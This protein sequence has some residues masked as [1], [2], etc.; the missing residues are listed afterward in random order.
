MRKMMREGTKPSEHAQRLMQELEKILTWFYDQ[1]VFSEPDDSYG[2]ILHKYGCLGVWY[3]AKYGQDRLVQELLKDGPFPDLNGPRS[4]NNHRDR[5]NDP[6]TEDWKWIRLSPISYA[7][8]IGDALNFDEKPENWRKDEA[9]KLVNAMVKAETQ[10]R[11]FG[12]VAGEDTE[13]PANRVLR[14]FLTKDW[15]DLEDVLEMVGRENWVRLNQDIPDTLG[16]CARFVSPEE[17]AKLYRM[18][19]KYVKARTAYFAVIYEA[20]NKGEA[21]PQALAAAKVALECWPGD[22]D[23]AREAKYLEQLAK[24]KLAEKKTGK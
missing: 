11:K 19:A 15:K 1:A 16:R 10:A 2:E 21:I 22:E 18:F 9:V 6:E 13:V 8:A 14:D 17:F 24:K 12:S 5:R 3:A 4:N 23:M 7:L 20:F